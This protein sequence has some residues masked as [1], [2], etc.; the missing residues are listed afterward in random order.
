M[1]IMAFF[2]EL[3]VEFPLGAGMHR[4]LINLEQVTRCMAGASGGGTVI[5]LTDGK[6]VTVKEGF[7]AVASQCSDASRR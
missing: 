4:Q 6:E 7:D 3:S 2:V 1:T 5:H